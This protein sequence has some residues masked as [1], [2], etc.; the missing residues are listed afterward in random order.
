M[1]VELTDSLLCF[2]CLFAFFY[3]SKNHANDFQLSLKKGDEN[4]DKFLLKI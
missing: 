1:P 4:V 2:F 3:F